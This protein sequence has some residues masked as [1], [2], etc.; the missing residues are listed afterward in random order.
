MKK[1]LQILLI[2]GV[3]IWEV[4]FSQGSTEAPKGKFS[5]Y[6]MGDYYYNIAR[7]GAFSTLANTASSGAAPGGKSMQAF[8]FRRIYFAY[9]YDISQQFTTRFRLEA[10]QGA[11]LGTTGDVLTSGKMSVFVKD[12]Y[13]KWKNIFSGSDLIFGIQPTPAYDV[14]EAAWGYRSLEKTIMDLRGIVDSRD[15]GLTLRGKLTGDGAVNYWLMI[16][17]SAGTSKPESDKYKRYY[18]HIQVKPTTNLQATLYVDYK[19]A[20]NVLD[21]SN[22]SVSHGTVTTALFVGYAEPSNFNLGLEGYLASQSNAYTPPGGSLGSRTGMGFTAYWSVFVQSDLTLVGRYDYFDPNTN[23]NS[24]GD[25]RNYIIAALDWKVDKN[26][27]IMPNLLF[28]TY[29]G[30]SGG[31]APDASVTARLTFYYVFH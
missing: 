5:G 1:L 10:D 22:N 27:S 7:D 17:N 8:Q 23:G 25:A 11:L 16:G 26:V 13:L 15:L 18:A 12:A 3:V 9:D 24:K 28:E 21:A 31:S 6:M 4:A 20:A 19:D 29:E 14:S 30:P 2:Q